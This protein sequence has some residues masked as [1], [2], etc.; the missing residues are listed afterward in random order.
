MSYENFREY[1]CKLKRDRSVTINWSVLDVD[2]IDA[3]DH[4]K[5]AGLQI[6]DIA[7]TCFSNAVEP[8]YY[9]NCE[10]K[11]AKKLKPLVY[12]H[13]RRF[14]NYGIKVVKGTS[15]AELSAQQNEFVD[16]FDVK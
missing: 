7:A 11:Y 14:I 9:G 2:A 3:L 16:L 10:I 1:L 15:A 8:D 12:R 13:N 5:R 6:S 4:K